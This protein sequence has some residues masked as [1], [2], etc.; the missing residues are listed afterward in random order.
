LTNAQWYTITPLRLSP[1]VFLNQ[2]NLRVHH[3]KGGKAWL[4]DNKKQA[5]VFYLPSYSP[6]L[7]R[8]FTVGRPQER[9]NSDKRRCAAISERVCKYFAHP[10]IQYAA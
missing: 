7:N 5:E 10:S 2:D 8:V 4:Q 9:K 3:A 1:K 6:E